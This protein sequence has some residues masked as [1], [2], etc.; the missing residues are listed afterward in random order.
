VFLIEFIVNLFGSAGVASEPLKSLDV[1]KRISNTKEPAESVTPSQN[2][3]IG[4]FI[5]RRCGG[6]LWLRGIQ[7]QSRS[8][9]ADGAAY[10][11]APC[12]IRLFS[13]SIL[14]LMCN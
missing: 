4:P 11:H 2:N 5:F 1:A 8:L 13:V 12:R 7:P 10:I 6:L 14:L 3:S 9:S